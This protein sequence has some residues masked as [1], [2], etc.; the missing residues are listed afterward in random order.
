[1]IAVSTLLSH[2]GCTSLRRRL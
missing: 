2:W 1:M